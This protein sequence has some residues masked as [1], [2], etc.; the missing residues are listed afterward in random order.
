[1]AV[2][3][4]AANQ[5]DQEVSHT[6]MPGM[7]N[8]GNVLQLVVDGLNNRP[9]PQQQFVLQGQRTLLHVLAPGRDQLQALGQQLVKERLGDVALV[10][11]ELAKQGLGHARQGLAV[12][13][14]ARSQPASQYF[15]PVIDAQVEFE[16]KNQPIEVLPR[17]AMPA[18]TLWRGIRL[19]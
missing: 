13:D 14:V 1:M 4:Q 9:F 10:S 3:D 15:A 19:L 5:V 12:I 16:A 7:F 11:E 18:K 8:L 17:A 2:G 6:A